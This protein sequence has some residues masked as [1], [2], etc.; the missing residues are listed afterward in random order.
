MSLCV[1][2]K[3]VMKSKRNLTQVTGETSSTVLSL[4]SHFV[5]DSFTIGAMDNFDHNEATMSG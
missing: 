3:E 1:S 5:G 2:Y 4:P